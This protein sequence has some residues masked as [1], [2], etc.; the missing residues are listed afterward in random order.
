M[1]ETLST[2]YKISV[3]HLYKTINQEGQWSEAEAIVTK[4]RKLLC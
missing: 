4:W 1:R 2:K 3:L